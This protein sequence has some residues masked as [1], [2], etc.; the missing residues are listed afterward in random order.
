[1]TAQTSEGTTGSPRA[2]GHLN[3]PCPDQDRAGSD[4]ESKPALMKAFADF[5][6]IG[7]AIPGANLNEAER[8]LLFAN[9][10]T[11]TPESCMKPAPVHPEEDRFDFTRADALVEL[12]RANGLTVNG[13]TLIW[14]EVC[15]DW[16]FSDGGRI[17]DRD[18]V[19]KRMRAHIAAVAGHFAGKVKSWD[20]V[21][22]AIDDGQDYLRKSK[23]FT[24]IGEDYIAEAFI[25]ARHADSR[26][27]LYY[28][29]YSIEGQPKR[30]KT[31]RLIR[32]LKERGAPVQG[33]GIQGHWQIDRIPFKDIEDA[34]IAFHHE[35]MQVMITELDLD[36]VPRETAGAEAGTREQA[37][38]DPYINGLPSEIQQRFTDQYSQ[39]FA[40][41]L[42]H[43]DKITRV[44]FWGLHDGRSWLNQWPSKRTNHAL[45]WDR[46]LQSKPALSAVLARARSPRSSAAKGLRL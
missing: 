30:D 46:A 9:F 28:N 19:L 3:Q 40:L 31:L 16:F 39:L 13:H 21:N 25:A 45:L 43:R 15:P 33:V 26:A 32:S 41:F 37:G 35:N 17:A 29:D 24:S 23:W 12:A 1:M 18:L 11:V 22:E 2:A 42:K 14:H 36:V 10:G 34:I 4:F 20:V 5:F 6:A 8:R 27:E 38:N 7:A 44:T